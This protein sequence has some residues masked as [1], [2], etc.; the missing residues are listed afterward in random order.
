MPARVGTNITAATIPP[1]IIMGMFI[2]S[3]SSRVE[4]G[5]TLVF[6]GNPK[7]RNS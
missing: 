6:T 5:L 1:T 7:G 3:T 2:A 4:F